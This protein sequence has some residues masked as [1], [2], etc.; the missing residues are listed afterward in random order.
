MGPASVVAF[1]YVIVLCVG[2]DLL[3]TGVPVIQTKLR[4][5]CMRELVDACSIYCAFVENVS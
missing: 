5:L 1:G 2:P 4:E 3:A